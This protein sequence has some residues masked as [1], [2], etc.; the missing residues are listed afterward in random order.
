MLYSN[1]FKGTRPLATIKHLLH[2]TSRMASNK[3]AFFDKTGIPLRIGD[4]PI[5]QPGP[6]DIVVKNYAVAINPVDFYQWSTGA[7]IK[8]YPAVLGHDVAGEVYDV[9]SSV[10]KF[11][12]GDRVAGQA[13]GFKTG[14]P[15]DGAF[16][17]YSNIPSKNSASLP[18]SI[19]FKDAAVLPL[20]ID[21][22]A[23]GLF[24]AES[25][26]L[27]WPEENSKPIEKTIIV[28]GASSSVG[29]MAV[30]LAKAAG[31]R[32]IGVASK[33]NADFVKEAGADLALD[34]RDPNVIEDAVKSIDKSSF[35]G[36]YDAIGNEASHKIVVPIFERIGG[37][38]RYATTRATPDNLP[39]DVSRYRIV[40]MGEHVFPIWKTFVADALQSGK[41]KCLPRPEV[42][43]TGLESLQ[44]GVERMGKG[45]SATKLVIEL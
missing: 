14:Q 15:Q 29:S 26:D 2:S 7:M 43:G 24:L 35:V 19:A 36:I 44:T 16:A 10:T 33:V 9:G 32:V 41:L 38:S 39:K 25:L 17:L 34:Y 11:K 20:A 37:K 42:V 3:A 45:V 18:E 22:A 27:P 21:T 13:W 23:T 8:N 4:A 28:Y 12:K 31:A 1:C 5:P 6:D 30:Q 40:G